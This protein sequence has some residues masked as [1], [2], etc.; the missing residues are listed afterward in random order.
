MH[1]WFT[2]QQLTVRDRGKEDFKQLLS[3]IGCSDIKRFDKEYNLAK[4]ESDRQNM[5][6]DWIRANNFFLQVPT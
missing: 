1:N 4:N 2:L 3:A 6:L 5:V